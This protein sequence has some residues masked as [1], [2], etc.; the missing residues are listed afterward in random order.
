MLGTKLIP[1]KNIRR[2]G[3]NIDWQVFSD[4]PST[5]EVRI[6]HFKAVFRRARQGV[7]D[8]NP[9]ANHTPGLDPNGTVRVL[10]QRSGE[11]T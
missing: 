8:L 11:H 10:D 1:G 3:M 9:S 7:R 5:Q 2:Y 6:N 4:A